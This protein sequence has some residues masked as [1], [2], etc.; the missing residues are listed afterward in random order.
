MTKYENISL[1]VLLGIFAFWFAEQA[2]DVFISNLYYYYLSMPSNVVDMSPDGTRTN[3]F[4]IFWPVAA[5]LFVAAGLAWV[6]PKIARKRE[7]LLPG[8]V[9]LLSA[10]MV[11]LVGYMVLSGK[12]YFPPFHPRATWLGY[13]W[14]GHQPTKLNLIYRPQSVPGVIYWPL[15]EIRYLVFKIFS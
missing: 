1:G 9:L 6:V 2:I 4:R 12:G 7:P 14:L 5:D 10:V 8:P 3:C 13:P 15:E 11:Y